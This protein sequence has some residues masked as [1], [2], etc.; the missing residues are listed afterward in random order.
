MLVQIRDLKALESLSL[1]NIRAYLTSREWQSTGRWGQRP[2]YIYVK[3]Q[4]GRSWEILV[5]LRDTLIDYAESVAGII[6]TLAEIEE[7]SQLDVFYDL[8]AAGADVIQIRS[9][10]DLALEHLSLRQNADFLGNAY[11]LLAAVARSV[12]KPRA[13]YRGK[14]SAEVAEYLNT[15]RPFIGQH[16]GYALTLHSPVPAEIGQ[17]DFGDDF[18][19][20]FP[21]R[22]MHK[23]AQA[24][25]YTGKAIDEAIFGDTLVPFERAVQFG[26][27]ANFCDAVGEL[28]KE[29]HGIE[30]DLAW[31]DARPSN[32]PH[33]HFPFSSKS[34]DVLAEAANAF[35]RNQPSYDE[36][37]V[38][39]V[40]QLEREPQEFDGRAVILSEWDKRL[41][42]IQ[43]EFD[44]SVY[45]T[46]IEAFQEHR[47]IS[48][49]GDIY[50]SGSRYELRN[51]RNLLVLE[52][53]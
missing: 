37:I 34:S 17:Q 52:D 7:R 10:N 9:A 11:D 47:S 8:A 1:V 42:R 4:A 16:Q 53:G 33:S 40:V 18:Q 30:I 41:I 14:P 24:L 31:A 20:P 12:E 23:L 35:R 46:V 3:E 48:L 5:P 45:D 28:A 25:D 32:L 44:Q 21:R 43:V 27:S 29:G 38:A 2:A 39:Q 15:V 50:R 19:A 36:Q 51:P 13:A 6:K 26:V 49:G 22:T